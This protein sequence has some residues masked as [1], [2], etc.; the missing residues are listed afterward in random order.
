[1]YN[2]HFMGPEPIK[3]VYDRWARLQ[4]RLSFVLN[5]DSSGLLDKTDTYPHPTLK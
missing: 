2:I 4:T 1:M 3:H 5:I